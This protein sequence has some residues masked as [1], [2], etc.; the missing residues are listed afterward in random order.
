MIAEFIKQLIE[1]EDIKYK[2]ASFG[3]LLENYIHKVRKN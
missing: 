3:Q 1:D 2:F